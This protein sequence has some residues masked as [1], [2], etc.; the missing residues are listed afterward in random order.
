MGKVLQIGSHLRGE[1]RYEDRRI[2]KGRIDGIAIFLGFIVFDFRT[3]IKA[4]AGTTG[5][6]EMISAMQNGGAGAPEEWQNKI[7]CGG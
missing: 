4:E 5:G 1:F 7:M 3:T 6:N 2:H